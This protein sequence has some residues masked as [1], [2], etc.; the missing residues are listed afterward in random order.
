MLN[1]SHKRGN[2]VGEKLVART[3]RDRVDSEVEKKN[4]AQEKLSNKPQSSSDLPAKGTCPLN[5]YENLQEIS[6]HPE[7]GHTPQHEE[8]TE[9]NQWHS[10]LVRGNQVFDSISQP[11]QR[12]SPWRIHH[13]GR[14][15]VNSTINPSNFIIPLTTPSCKGTFKRRNRPRGNS[16]SIK[17][18]QPVPAR[19]PQAVEPPYPS[20][21]S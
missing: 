14:R 2:N 16:A 11:F 3:I 10:V 1:M 7:A 5:R 21:R 20:R 19:H 15:G 9:L 6:A 13:I 8:S 4:K 17:L 18:R 12:P